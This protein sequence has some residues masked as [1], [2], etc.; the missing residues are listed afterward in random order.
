M[1]SGN[2]SKNGLAAAL[3]KKLP[4]ESLRKFVDLLELFAALAP[5][6]KTAGPPHVPGTI[7]MSCYP[8]PIPPTLP[9]GQIIK[10]ARAAKD[11]RPIPWTVDFHNGEP[12]VT[13]QRPLSWTPPAPADRKPVGKPRHP[14][15]VADVR[16]LHLRGLT[17]QQIATRLTAELRSKFPDARAVTKGIVRSRLNEADIRRRK[18]SAK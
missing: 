17:H 3:A 12:P 11:G 7:A 10:R 4:P 13:I 15:T 5:N 1:T 9:M 14:I 6:R 16:S 8:T 2:G 18:R